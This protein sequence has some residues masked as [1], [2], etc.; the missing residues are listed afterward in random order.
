MKKYKRI[1]I[2]TEGKWF[3]SHFPLFGLASQGRTKKE[4]EANLIEAVG[5][6]VVTML[7]NNSVNIFIEEM[8]K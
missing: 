4:A 1:Y 2:E 7:E 3:V 8:R 6:Y 5:L